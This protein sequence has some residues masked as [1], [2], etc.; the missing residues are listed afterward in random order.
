MSYADDQKDA[1][2]RRA[3]WMK[4]VNLAARQANAD[5]MGEVMK[6]DGG[7][8]KN[9]RDMLPEQAL[10]LLSRGWAPFRPVYEQQDRIILEVNSRSRSVI[11]PTNP[12]VQ[13]LVTEAVMKSL[14]AEPAWLETSIQDLVKPRHS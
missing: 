12:S 9:L 1:Q 2:K 6:P 7:I 13:G 3:D 14:A 11:D 10:K 4:V 8:L 5:L